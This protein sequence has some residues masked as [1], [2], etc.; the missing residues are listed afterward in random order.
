MYLNPGNSGF[1]G[2]RNDI[3]V[4]KSGLISLINGTIDTPRRLTCISRP[5]RFG[6]SF[7]AK[8]LCAYYDKTCD[9]SVLFDDL[10]IAL[11][12]N[13]NETYK[14][15]LNKYD[16]IYIDMSYIKPFT[17]NYK[18]IV[19]YLSQKINEELKASY[20]EAE[21]SN[22]LPVSMINAVEIT[23]NKFIMIIDEW[24]APIREKP[25]TQRP[26]LE[27]LRTLFKGSGTTDKI[28]AAVYMTGILP[29][30]KDGS[31]S[32]IS[33]FKEFTVVKPRKFGK[34]A[35]FTEKEVRTLCQEFQ[36]DFKMMKRW[37]DGYYMSDG[38]SLFNPRSVCCALAEGNCRNYWT[39]TGPMNEVAECIEHNVEE[40]RE[41]VVRMV[42]G[43]PVEIQLEGY[44]AAEQILTH[45]N[46]ILSAMVVYG[47]LSYYNGTLRIP[48][49]ELM[50]KFQQ[51]LSRDSMGG[52]K[53]IVETSKKM[54]EATLAM[55]EQIVA[56]LLEAVHDREIPFLVYNDENALS[57]VITLCYLY[58]RKDYRIEREEKTGKGY[59]D[60]I[61]YPQ[62]AHRPAILLELKVNESAEAALAQIRRKGYVQKVAY[63]EEILLVGISYDKKQKGN[64]CRIENQPA[65]V[66][67]HTRIP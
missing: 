48:N 25:E 66:Q 10:K 18:T 20:P 16:V 55:D 39:E 34:Y 62:R 44:S 54:L 45:R 51:V 27:F 15:H 60:Y 33:D 61:F 64:R 24:D 12:E 7:A 41:D 21:T 6:K 53:Q 59:C 43:I 52:V 31:Q 29:I 14:Q 19:P 63:C 65:P 47:F 56:N 11:D 8:M 37:Y 38:Q 2:I 50:E 40:V 35:G 1:T 46:E 42:A 5:R 32:A 36:R 17:D 26:Y 13:M 30:K 22:E 23:G 9:S 67:K 58:A 49:H 3:Y 57:C 28:F 4:D